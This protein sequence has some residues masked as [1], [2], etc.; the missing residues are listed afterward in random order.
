MQ[1]DS[2]EQSQKLNFFNFNREALTD[3][4]GLRCGMRPGARAVRGLA[5]GPVGKVRSTSGWACFRISSWEAKQ[6]VSTGRTRWADLR[7]R[8]RFG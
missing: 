6:T 3:P 1:T 5:S 7:I 8:G 2:A 4:P